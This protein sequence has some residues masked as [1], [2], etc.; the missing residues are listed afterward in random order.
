MSKWMDCSQKR[1]NYI[2][3]ENKQWL[4]L[5]RS[6]TT[7]G[8]RVESQTSIRLYTDYLAL[9]MVFTPQS[10]SSKLKSRRRTEL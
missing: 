4:L 2:S 3:I 8:C 9:R 1:M 10:I 6:M 7:K 5:L